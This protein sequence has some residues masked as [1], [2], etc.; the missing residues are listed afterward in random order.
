MGKAQG[1]LS[2]NFTQLHTCV[3]LRPRLLPLGL[4]LP[5]GGSEHRPDQAAATEFPGSWERAFPEQHRRSAGRRPGSGDGGGRLR[6][7]RRPARPC[8]DHRQMRAPKAERAVLDNDD[9]DECTRASFTRLRVHRSAG[10]VA[11][12][13][14][15]AQPRSHGW[16]GNAPELHPRRAPGAPRSPRGRPIPP[17]GPR[18]PLGTAPL[19]RAGSALTW[20]WGF[21]HF[22]A[23]R[24]QPSRPRPCQV[25][26]CWALRHPALRR[27]IGFRQRPRA[28]PSPAALRDAAGRRRRRRRPVPPARR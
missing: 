17:R 1:R 27:P 5:S 11:K 8:L 13:A 19:R 18:S 10:P 14:S 20:E 16:A 6:C 25:L 21:R 12:D 3:A 15:T 23:A 9:E 4:F 26:A 28:A 24:P 2:S 7:P 22:R